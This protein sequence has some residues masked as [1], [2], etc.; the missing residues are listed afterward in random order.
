MGGSNAEV[1]TVSTTHS[2]GVHLST[3]QIN[4]YDGSRFEVDYF[5]DEGAIMQ[6]IFIDREGEC[7][8]AFLP[9]NKE[10]IY[11]QSEIE[12]CAKILGV[13]PPFGNANRG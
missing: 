8:E 13:R 3:I 9:K 5:Y 7:V 2:L 1:G 10:F 6:I 12:R 11:C 4:C